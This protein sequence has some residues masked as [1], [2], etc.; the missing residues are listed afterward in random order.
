M[1]LRNQK[2]GPGWVTYQQFK[3][4]MYQ[5]TL[6]EAEQ[7]RSMFL[8]SSVLADGGQRMEVVSATSGWWLVAFSLLCIFEF[9]AGGE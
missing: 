4:G 8:R 2:M 3:R 9:N 6:R 7:N 1:L 5:A